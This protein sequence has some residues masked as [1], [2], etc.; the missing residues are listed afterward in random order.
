MMVV[1]LCLQDNEYFA[2][3]IADRE[4]EM[5]AS[6]EA[7]LLRLKEDESRKELLEEEV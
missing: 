2:S 3:L 1:F 6:K 5:N 7:Q 4:K